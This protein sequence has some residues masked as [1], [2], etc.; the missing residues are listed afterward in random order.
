MAS[1][2]PPKRRFH[3]LSL[4]TTTSAIPGALSSSGAEHAAELRLHAEQREVRRAHQ[5]DLDALRLVDLG[6]IRV[7]GIDAGDV[8]EEVGSIAIRVEL[9]RRQ[10]DVLTAEA[11]HVGRH[12]HETVGL[13][14]RQRPEDDGVDDG[15]HRRVGPDAEGERRRRPPR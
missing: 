5:Q 14:K 4:R 6:E 8:L 10:A 1:A 13:R 12:P 2:R 15:K 3:R 9:G 7:D 11:G